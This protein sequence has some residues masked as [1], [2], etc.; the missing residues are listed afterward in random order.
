ML[1]RLLYTFPKTQ[2]SAMSQLTA[3]VK[4]PFGYFK[5]V[6][7][8]LV[9]ALALLSGCTVPKNEGFAIYLTRDDVSPDRMEAL[10][11]VAL[12]EYPIISSGDII[13]FNAQTHELKLTEAA[14]ERILELE[15]P[16]IGKSFMVCVDQAP[17]YWGAFWTP[18]SSIS[19][20]GVTIW[21]PYDDKGPAVVT[22]ELGY[23]SSSFYS[24]SDPR[25][26]PA[27]IES[28]EEAGKLVE[29]LRLDQVTGLPSSA[30]GYELY[31]WQENGQWR[32]TLITGTNRDKT[33]EEITS[34]E[35]YIS[36]A[37]FVNIHVA[38]T[39]AI[40]EVLGRMPPGEFVLWCD[41]LHTGQSIRPNLEL[42]PAAITNQI[43]E[44]ARQFGLDFSV[45]VSP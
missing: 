14:F 36:E 27:V 45:A 32:F 13:S 29:K 24:G 1:M 35:D 6:P 8:L 26:D 22:L 19:F 25:N 31:S 20:G 30:K 11:H 21:K 37:G 41:E 18:V 38:G 34:A 44:Y 28:L 17:V 42:P 4:I 39:G 7:L 33:I 12:A 2:L 23:P 5:S 9:A 16:I 10:S 3:N 40:K 43:V 15:V